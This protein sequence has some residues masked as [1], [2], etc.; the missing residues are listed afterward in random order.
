M[1]FY[2][3]L[4]YMCQ[5]SYRAPE[6]HPPFLWLHDIDTKIISISRPE[7]FVEYRINSRI[8]VYIIS[9]C[10]YVHAFIQRKLSYRPTKGSS[11]VTFLNLRDSLSYVG[12]CDCHSVGCWEAFGTR[13]SIFLTITYFRL[14]ITWNFPLLLPY[15]LF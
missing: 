6:I 8:I 11:E 3:V 9:V 4:L 12:L 13:L 2:Q 7:N 15:K 1:T 5:S 10:V 14:P